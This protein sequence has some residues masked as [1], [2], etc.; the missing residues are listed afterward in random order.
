MTL[1]SSPLRI[2]SNKSINCD[3]S[4]KPKIFCADFKSNSVFGFKVNKALSNKES[5]SLLQTL[6][7][8]SLLTLMHHRRLDLPPCP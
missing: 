7:K 3:L 6:L 4:K 8:F 1:I 5:A 2:N